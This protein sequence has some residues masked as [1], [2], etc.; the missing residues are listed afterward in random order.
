MQHHFVLADFNGLFD[1]LLCLSHADTVRTNTG[2]ELLLRPGQRVSAYED[3]IGEQGQP[4]YLV[5]TGV[6]EAS[7]AWLACRGSR[8]AL[9]IDQ[10]GVRHEATL[11]ES[12]G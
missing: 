4:E 5:A 8:W 1:D 10:R 3:D 2:S 7:P 9:R 12:G 6:V 11:S